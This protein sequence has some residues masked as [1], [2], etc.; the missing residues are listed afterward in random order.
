[1][2]YPVRPNVPTSLAVPGK[3]TK[4]RTSLN[5][6]EYLDGLSLPFLIFF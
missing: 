1:M 6:L 3:Y 2:Q 5:V 4:V